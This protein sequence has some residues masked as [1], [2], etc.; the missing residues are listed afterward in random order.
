MPERTGAR[1]GMKWRE[2]PR[3]SSSAVIWL[4]RKFYG[5]LWLACPLSVEKPSSI[6]SS[7]QFR[8]ICCASKISV[9]VRHLW[10]E[11]CV[12]EITQLCFNVEI[13]KK[14]FG[15]CR[16]LFPVPPWTSRLRQPS[17]PWGKRFWASW[18]V[19]WTEAFTMTCWKTS[20]NHNRSKR[21][22]EPIRIISNYQELAFSAEKIAPTRR[23]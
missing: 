22:D 15:D 16:I 4:I 1:L 18:N 9:S 6:I 3:F 12:V 2:M 14:A 20:T 7:S 8:K 17:R 11:A 21:R 23:G 10:L 19:C 13:K 5:R